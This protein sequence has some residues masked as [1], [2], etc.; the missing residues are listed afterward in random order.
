MVPSSDKVVFNVEISNPESCSRVPEAGARDT[1]LGGIGTDCGQ[2]DRE[3]RWR[4]LAWR[5]RSLQQPQHLPPPASAAGWTGCRTAVTPVPSNIR[6][7]LLMVASARGTWPPLRPHEAPVDAQAQQQQLLTPAVTRGNWDYDHWQLGD[8]FGHAGT[9]GYCWQPPPPPRLTLLSLLPPPTHCVEAVPPAVA[10]G[11]LLRR[12]GTVC[13]P[14][15]DYRPGDGRTRRHATCS[16]HQTSTSTPPPARLHHQ[17]STS[18]PPPSDLH[19]HASTMGS[20]K[21]LCVSSFQTFLCPAVEEIKEVR[22]KQ[23]LP[24][25]PQTTTNLGPIVPWVRSYSEGCI[26]RGKWEGLAVDAAAAAAAA[27]STVPRCH[28]V[29]PSNAR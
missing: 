8:F 3:Q 25:W 7:F 20:V 12:R 28:T 5:R 15:L 18:T 24:S 1:E 19:Q 9:L 27:A 26:N 10:R 29:I 13:L 23:W 17:T 4:G 16:L 14:R 2:L 22:A 21:V 11:N 6:V